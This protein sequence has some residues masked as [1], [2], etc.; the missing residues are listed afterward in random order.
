MKRKLLTIVASLFIGIGLNAQTYDSWGLSDNGF[1]YDTI[2][3]YND[4][5]TFTFTGIPTGGWG[6]A[7]LTAYFQGDFGS[8][9]EYFTAYELSTATNLGQLGVNG[10]NDCAPEASDNLTFATSDLM[11]WSSGGTFVVQLVISSSVGFS[12]NPDRAKVNLSFNYCAFGTPTEYAD[13][14]VDTS[15]VCPHNDITL[16]GIPTGGVFSGTNVSGNTFDASGLASGG[17][18]V[19]YT[20]TD[21]IGCV[22]SASQIVNVYNAPPNVSY[23]LCEGGDSPALSTG[24]S[25][26]FLYSDDIENTSII[27]TS[28]NYIYGP[29][30]Q[31]PTVIYQSA[32]APNGYF[33]LDSAYITGSMIIDHDN[34]TGDDR[35]GIAVSN[36]HVYVVGDNSTARYDL[37]LQNG[38]VLPQRDGLFSDLQT[39]QLWTLY[40][41]FTSQMPNGNSSFLSDAIMKLDDMLNPT[42]EMILLSQS[43]SMSTGSDNNGILAGYGEVG[44]SDGTSGN[45]WVVNLINGIVTDLGA[46]YPN[47]YWGENWADWGVLGNDGMDY[48][49]YYRDGNT[50]DIAKHNLTTDNISYISNFN[51]VS[52]L[53]TFT[54]SI[55][56]NRIYFHYESNGQFGGNSETLGYID[57]DFTIVDLP[58]GIIAG[59]PSEIEFIFNDIDLGPDTTVCDYNTPFVLEAGFGYNSYTWNGNNN[60]WNI[61]PVSTSGP[62]ILE[63]VDAANCILIDTIDVT[64]DGCL[65]IDELG[66]EGFVLYPNP[67]N[68]TFNL[69]FGTETVNAEINIIDMMGKTVHQETIDN[70]VV[71][72]TINTE[73]LE[74]GLYIVNV[75]TNN[76]LYQATF[77]VE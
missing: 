67:N 22:T 66:K 47:Y 42:G 2:T 45:V 40:N 8:T 23:L 3:Q 5:L 58:G 49:A 51:D 71:N 17:Y 20:Y 36:T 26:F 48:Y 39:G 18:E 33:N 43:I 16:T 19:T 10:F 11:T 68:G 30:T 24:N 50:D 32:F 15:G 25:S 38:I 62:V 9:S 21:G 64:I 12:C 35:A 60:N 74:A 65:G 44:L 63:V 1:E 14:D 73:R 6:N 54:V 37:D 28:A 41:S 69:Q 4:T 13:F 72:A 70:N 31:S 76:T 27:D 57:A 55:A 59:C 7:T 61:Y 75:N 53:C 29:V 52:D 46:H 56:T 77:I 34:L